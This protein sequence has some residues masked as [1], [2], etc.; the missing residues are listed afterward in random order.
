MVHSFAGFEGGCGEGL[1]QPPG[2]LFFKVW[3]LEE[4][5]V[6]RTIFTLWKILKFFKKMISIFF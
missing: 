5:K 3:K 6:F 1:V 4:E 2:A